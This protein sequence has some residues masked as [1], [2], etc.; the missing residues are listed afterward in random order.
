MGNNMDYFHN[1]LWYGEI[2][3][4]P[5]ELRRL[6]RSDLLE[7]LLELS[8]E[9]DRLLQEVKQLR[10][11]LEQR[12]IA[13]EKCGSMAEAALSLNGVFQAT[14]SACEQYIENVKLRCWQMEKDTKEKCDKMLLDAGS[15]KQE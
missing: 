1:I 4:S 2:E 15:R 7:M 14:Q 8:K 3:M 9:N 12:R 11:E 13:I 6:N 5:K 10:E